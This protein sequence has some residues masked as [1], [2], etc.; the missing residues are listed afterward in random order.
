MFAKQIRTTALFS[1]LAG[2]LLGACSQSLGSDHDDANPQHEHSPPTEQA[3]GG[4]SSVG[5]S[6][7]ADDQVLVAPVRVIALRSE[8][9]EALDS[10]LSDEQITARFDEVNRIWKQ[11]NIRFE[12]ESI[13]RPQ[14]QQAASFQAAIDSGAKKAQS[15]LSQIYPSDQVLDEGWTVVLLEDFGAMPPGVFSC[16]SGLVFAA[17]YFG[18]QKIEAPT[19]VL[20][21]ELGHA[22]NLPHLCGQ[23]ENL[24]CATGKQP[25]KLN[26]AQ[27]DDA[28]SQ[29]QLGRPASCNSKSH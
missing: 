9:A 2:C 8:E 1:V 26:Q 29:A 5:G 23:G 19:N 28:R 14:A 18:K 10:S 3:A 16:V 15:L 11:A 13:V 12:I 4:S 27:I 7:L 6:T 17:R 24:M 21:H 25:E 20:A 22:L